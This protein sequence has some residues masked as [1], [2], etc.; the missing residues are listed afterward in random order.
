MSQ[1][2]TT[3]EFSKLRAFFW[4][5]YKYELKKVLPMFFMFFFINFNYTILRDT[6]DILILNSSGAGTI[7]FLKVWGTIPA[8]IIFMIVY[9]KLSN[10]LSKPK[11]FYSVVTPFLVFFLLFAF[12]LYPL[13]NSLHPHAFCDMLESHAPRLQGFIAI[14]R[15]WTFSLFYVI[16]ELWGSAM[17]SLLFWQFAND[18]TKV[19]ESK[20]FYPFFLI[21]ANIAMLFSGPLITYFSRYG[22]SAPLGTDPW[23]VS[24]TYLMPMAFFAGLMIMAL[25]YYTTKKVLTDPR[26]YDSSEQ[27][28]LKKEKPKMSLIESFKYLG[29]S[30]YMLYLAT[31]VVA[32]GVAMNIVEVSWKHQVKLFFPNENA[33]GEF[34]GI[35][36]FFTGLFTIFMLLVVSG[37]VIRKFGW[38]FAAMVTPIVLALTGVAFFTFILFKDTPLFA[39]LATSSIIFVAVVVGAVQNIL[40]KSS[41]Y[42]L[43]DPTKEM[44][45]IPLDQEMKVKGKAA[46]DV[47]GSRLGK[48][49]GSLIQQF[50]III[51]GIGAMVPFNAVILLG[52][53]AIW[54]ISVKALKKQFTTLSKKKEEEEE[55]AS[56]KAA[57]K[58]KPSFEK[59]GV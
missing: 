38:G 41:K 29:K 8:A 36:S 43:F 23:Q 34:Y 35:F 20:R 12:V 24:L 51:V 18:I 50:L 52:V 19:K 25:Y 33:M 31:L 26:F 27:K 28:K 56:K 54:M 4:P 15:N 3:P 45:Y 48:S 57:D 16:A 13:R 11:L 1:T 5:V 10:K 59:A 30:K 53:V 58:K 7:P 37:N 42:S 40:T 55:E 17:I 22:K 2:A 14:L 6:K 9:A 39:S 47:V 44:A 49:G 32:Y 46:I 21:G